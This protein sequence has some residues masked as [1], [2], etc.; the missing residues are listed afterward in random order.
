MKILI[1][2][3]FIAIWCFTLTSCSSGEAPITASEEKL[4]EVAL[5]EHVPEFKDEEIKTLYSHY[6]LLKAGLIASNPI[7]TQRAANNLKAAFTKAGKTKGTELASKIAAS[8]DLSLQRSHFDQLSAEMES[9]IKTAG[10]KSGKIYKQFC[11]M[12]NNGNGAYWLASESEIKNP[13]YGD[14]M[15]SCGEVKEEIK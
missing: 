8:G 15:L 3:S 4:T 10:L 13:Y 7:G 14:E 2:L 1:S 6:M 11:P 5:S 9:A 12:A